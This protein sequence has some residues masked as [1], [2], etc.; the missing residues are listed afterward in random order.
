LAWIA[1]SRLKQSGKL[2]EIARFGNLAKQKG[3][4][5]GFSDSLLEGHDTH[6]PEWAILQPPPD[7]LRILKPAYSAAGFQLPRSN[8]LNNGKL[9]TFKCGDT[10]D[11][12]VDGK[13]TYKQSV[14]RPL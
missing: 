3:D 8:W 11:C 7:P 12:Q 13:T 2:L 10:K 14:S 6:Y 4:F 5:L 9:T 1:K